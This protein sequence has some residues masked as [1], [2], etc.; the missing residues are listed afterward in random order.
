MS[1]VSFLTASIQEEKNT[2]TNFSPQCY[3]S[4]ARR[5][6]I[7]FILDTT[8]YRV[9]W[10]LSIE[11]SRYLLMWYL[12]ALVCERK[13]MRSIRN[14]KWWYC[15]RV[16]PFFFNTDR[17]E[18]TASVLKARRQGEQNKIERVNW[19][20]DDEWWWKKQRVKGVLERGTMGNEEKKCRTVCKDKLDDFLMTLS[21]EID[22]WRFECERKES[23]PLAH[24][25][26]DSFSV[27]SRMSLRDSEGVFNHLMKHTWMKKKRRRRCSDSVTNTAGRNKHRPNA[28][29]YL[30]EVYCRQR[31]RDHDM[32]IEREREREKEKNE[33]TYR[34]E[35]TSERDDFVGTPANNAHNQ[36]RRWRRRRRQ[37]KKSR[38]KFI[39]L[40][41]STSKPIYRREK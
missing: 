25:N 5:G 9:V 20:W 24:W 35:K 11:I 1:F 41:S 10:R 31:R 13:T 16:G 28:K 29:D 4:I 2:H 22:S 14:N 34:K 19:A 36:A 32:C 26:K 15:S 7:R 33:R 37:R 23:D 17:L 8:L 12:P 27:L 38:E 39:F 3:Y 30:Y 6:N 18:T 21:Y 40:Y